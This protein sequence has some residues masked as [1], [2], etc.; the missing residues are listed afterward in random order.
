MEINEKLCDSNL[1]TSR[2]LLILFCIL[3]A[4]LYESCIPGT[5]YFLFNNS[6]E[7]IVVTIGT[8]VI[9]IAPMS[10]AKLE[11]WDN[12]PE[13]IIIS[14]SKERWYYPVRFRI[15]GAFETQNR[16]ISLPV[17]IFARPGFAS[18]DFYF[19]INTTGVVFP[20]PADRTPPVNS[21]MFESFRIDPV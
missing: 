3:A 8:T 5:R 6:D 18:I 21:D 19:Q 20:I 13:E 11:G 10:L 15:G 1:K 16:I 4:F 17:K 7:T 2:S 12:A 14:T 9:D